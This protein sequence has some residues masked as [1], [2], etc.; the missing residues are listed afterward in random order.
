MAM[1]VCVNGSSLCAWYNGIVF[2]ASIGGGAN[3][4]GACCCPPHFIGDIMPPFAVQYKSLPY[5]YTGFPAV[6]PSLFKLLSLY[7]DF[8]FG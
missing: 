5:P 4:G 7:P 1:Q 2:L 3:C 8:K 6:P